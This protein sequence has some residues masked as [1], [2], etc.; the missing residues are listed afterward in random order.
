M[1][2]LDM[3]TDWES[4]AFN[5]SAFIAGLFLLQYGNDSFIDNMNIILVRMG[6]PLTM[7][8]LITAGTEW[9]EVADD[10][11]FNPFDIG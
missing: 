1:S 7:S 5:C 2:T 10:L 4:V 8:H 9:E 6:F 11:L 3:E